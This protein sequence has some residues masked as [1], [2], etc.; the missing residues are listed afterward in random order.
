MS[1]KMHLCKPWQVSSILL[2]CKP[3]LLRLLVTLVVVTI[4]VALFLDISIR[5]QFEGGSWSIPAHVFT[6]PLDLYV[7]QT[8][9]ANDV[10]S[11]LADLGYRDQTG[12][13]DP[14]TFEYS[15]SVLTI[16]ARRFQF[17]DQLRDAHRVRI[18]FSPGNNKVTS[19]S[20]EG[21][22]LGLFQLEGRLFGS[23]SPASHEDR[24]LLTQEQVPKGLIDALIA[25]E[26]RNFYSHWGISPIGIARAA[27]ANL[28]TGRVVQGGSTITQQLVKNY[29]LTSDR[30][31]SRK[32]VE[33]VMA[34]LLEF[35]YSKQQ[36]ML[37]YI[38]EIYLGQAG[39]RAI[40]GFGLGSQFLFGRQLQELNQ[41]E[42]ATLAAIVKGPSAY[43]PLRHPARATERRNLVLQVMQ[44]EGFITEVQS[45][46]LQQLPLG[47]GGEQ[48]SLRRGY[49]DFLDMVRQ[50]LRMG[51]Q[52]AA[53]SN[54]GLRVYTTL[55]P[56]IQN[57]VEQ[58]I[59]DRLTTIE[60]SRNMDAGTL[61]AAAIVLRTDS[62]EV[63]A[64]AGG[65]NREFAGYN[66]AL[67]AVRPV[68][69]LLKPFVYLAALEQPEIYGLGT[70][71]QDRAIVVSQRGSEDWIPENY[72]GEEH[73][74]VPLIDGLKHSYN[75]ATVNL[76]MEVGLDTFAGLL[77][78][79]KYQSSDPEPGPIY[80]SALLG[81]LPMTV[82]DVADLYLTLANSGF[83]TPTKSVRSVLSDRGEP[84]GRY[85]LSI[86][87]V[88]EPESI[89]LIVYA[90]QQVVTS[91]TARAIG[92]R[93]GGGW[94]FAGKTGTSD[95]Y[96][97]SWYAGF[98]G[99]YL[100]VIWVGRDDNKTTGLSG[101]SGAAHIWADTFANILTRPLRSAA[102]ESI[103]PVLLDPKTGLRI[104]ETCS[105][106][107]ILPYIVGY[108]PAIQNSC[109]GSAEADRVG[110]QNEFKT[111][112][113]VGEWIKGLFN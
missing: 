23:V 100:M 34:V 83:K 95:G 48:A 1:N 28:V 21:E 53:L 66:R 69:S 5:K 72:N 55:D 15:R 63:V 2:A 33:I 101:A 8:I 4:A 6:R 37:A 45:G 17:W 19:V 51:Y 67:D 14:G 41:A 61:E 103:K 36:I 31:I 44:H 108:E 85:P 56:R 54:A 50:Q 43:N 7:G 60:K 74:L 111:Q 84:L 47:T 20:S 80:P 106:G 13:P 35:H 91:G 25:I 104:A 112:R 62:G 86:E 64:L 29:Y 40:H 65:R 24:E 102:L 32:L 79:F 9:T 77:R 12:A 73:G 27:V 26:D 90:L 81:A 10:L 18:G 71:I 16:H 78:R 89:A 88:A 68:G 76:G 58:S 30:T 97:D 113:S 11:E 107:V 3:W 42:L 39:N 94:G 87:Q 92:D 49:P 96:R 22:S 46:Q 75:L 70:L 59:S 98:S 109:T 105:T 110:K 82:S 38:N 93:F 99:D 57:V 52:D